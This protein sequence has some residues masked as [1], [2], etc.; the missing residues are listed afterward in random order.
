[1]YV[2]EGVTPCMQ[3]MQLQAGDTVIFSR[4]DPEDKL[5]IGCRKAT[6]L[7][8]APALPN[9]VNGGALTCTDNGNLPTVGPS[10]SFHYIFGLFNSL[11]LIRVPFLAKN[12]TQEGTSRRELS[13]T[14]WSIFVF[15]I[16]TI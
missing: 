13:G 16:I 14:S 7:A 6:V 2:L 12:M 3:N 1:M 11:L 8:D 4:L 5:V 9:P 10:F 15:L